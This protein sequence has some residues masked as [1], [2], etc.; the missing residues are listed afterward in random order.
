M[1]KYKFVEEASG[2]CQRKKKHLF[3]ISEKPY[4]TIH[5]KEKKKQFPLVYVQ[6]VYHMHHLSV[7]AKSKLYIS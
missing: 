6:I 3:N 4:E 5:K 1:Q 7:Q 2:Y